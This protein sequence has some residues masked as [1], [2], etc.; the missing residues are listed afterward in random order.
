MLFSF[1]RDVNINWKHGINALPDMDKDGK[2]RISIVLWGMAPHVVEESGSPAMLTDNTRGYGHSIHSKPSMGSSA[3][4]QSHGREVCRD[5]KRGS[6]R[7][8]D[9][10]KHIHQ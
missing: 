2:G 8:G 6:C 3:S 9:S 4:D 7:F 1:G 10:C 5:F